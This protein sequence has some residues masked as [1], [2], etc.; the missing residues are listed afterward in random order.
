MTLIVACGGVSIEE[1]RSRGPSSFHLPQ[2]KPYHVIGL[3][4]MFT[5]L[6]GD[7]FPLRLHLMLV[8]S[9]T[10]QGCRSLRQF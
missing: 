7:I 6:A 9:E 1:T 5:V 10:L 8:R 2:P 3:R 4:F